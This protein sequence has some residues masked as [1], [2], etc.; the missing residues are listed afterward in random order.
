M[1]NPS[2][3]AFVSLGAATAAAHFWVPGTARGYAA[4]EIAARIDNGVGTSKW[5]LDTPALCVD[6]DRLEPNIE[7][8]QA[9]AK[10]FGLATRPH[11]KTHAAPTSRSSSS[12]PA[13]S[14]SAAPSSVRP[15]P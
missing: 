13:P 7:T 3:R 9:S 6:L 11:A 5:D 14:A 12:P 15:R 4:A 10:R 2:R 1:S 8:M